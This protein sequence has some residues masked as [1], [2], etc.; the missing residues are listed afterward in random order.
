MLTL[1]ARRGA[2]WGFVLGWLA[3]I[4][5][6]FCGPACLQRYALPP[7][8]LVAGPLYGGWFWVP[9]LVAWVY[10]IFMGLAASRWQRGARLQFRDVVQFLCVRY[11]RLTGV[12]LISCCLGMLYGTSAYWYADMDGVTVQTIW[13]S[14]SV[15][16]PW[17]DIKER[18]ITCYRGKGGPETIYKVQ[19]INGD[20]LGLGDTTN[21]RGFY[22]QFSTLLALPKNATLKIN[23]IKDCPLFVR[24][25]L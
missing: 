10:F 7:T 12:L 20:I 13:G 24:E 9:A 17:A 15:T 4:V 1:T 25:R 3:T 19:M 2:K 18:L 11:G 5:G 16:Y 21:T 22:T 6:P 23:D 14:R 8:G